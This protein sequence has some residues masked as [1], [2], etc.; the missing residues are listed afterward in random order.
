MTFILRIISISDRIFGEECLDCPGLLD[1]LVRL[2][3]RVPRDGGVHARGHQ[4]CPAPARGHA[5]PHRAPL[6]AR[7]PSNRSGYK[8]LIN[9]YRRQIRI[10]KFQ[11]LSK[12]LFTLQ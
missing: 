4:A 2:A 11:T 1:Q 12:A 8:E 5:A 10:L 9:I 6:K 7:P 3:G